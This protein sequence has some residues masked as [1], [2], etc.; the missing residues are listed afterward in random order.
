MAM[1]SNMEITKILNSLRAFL[2]NEALGLLGCS[3]LILGIYNH[4]TSSQTVLQQAGDE[5]RPLIESMD[6]FVMYKV[7]RLVQM[8][9]DV[10]TRAKNMAFV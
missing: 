2:G 3:P 10:S 7:D 1:N 8:H 6:K 9:R 5:G 4:L